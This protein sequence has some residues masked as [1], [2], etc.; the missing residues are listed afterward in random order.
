MLTRALALGDRIGLPSADPITQFCEIRAGE[1][2]DFGDP[3]GLFSN[4]REL[5]WYAGAASASVAAI[6]P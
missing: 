3:H 1:L 2:G 4:P 6:R 5:R